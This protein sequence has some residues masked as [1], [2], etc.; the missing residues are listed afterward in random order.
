MFNTEEEWINRTVDTSLDD[1]EST[2]TAKIFDADSID[3]LPLSE[4]YIGDE[5]DSIIYC[6]L[7]SND[8]EKSN[9]LVDA[10]TVVFIFCLFFVE[11]ALTILYVLSANTDF[12]SQIIAHGIC[13]NFSTWQFMEDMFRKLHDIMIVFQRICETLLH[14]NIS[15][16]CKIIYFHKN[17]HL[18]VFR[19]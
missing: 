14:I 1:T 16:R 5:E 7:L 2:N 8:L 17:I 3:A 13:K 12:Q 18:L 4:E 11:L 15:L 19:T 6:D 9:A 10:F